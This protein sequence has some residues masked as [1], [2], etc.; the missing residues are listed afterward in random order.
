MD[1]DVAIRSGDERT[2][3]GFV[4]LTDDHERTITVLDPRIVPHGA[5]P[6]GWERLR[7]VDAVY[8][9]GGDAAALRRARD[10]RVLV[11]T[12]RAFDV[13]RE[14]GVE[15]DVLV[16]S[17]TDPGERVDAWALDPSPR[18]VVHTR[19][20][21]GGV[22]STREGDAGAVACGT[23]ARPGR[24][25]VRLRR[26][27]RGGTDVRARSADAGARPRSTSARCAVRTA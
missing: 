17:A 27:V 26:F 11:A 9:T 13:I 1:L 20:A 8:F 22:W 12:P 4:H 19:G 5:D 15:L 18:L 21:D 24:R 14:A 25:R 3:R 23:A 16:S 7:D 10:A 6:L 2:R